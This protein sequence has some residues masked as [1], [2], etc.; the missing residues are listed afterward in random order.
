MKEINGW[1][2]G[3]WVEDEQS[4]VSVLLQFISRYMG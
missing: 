3:G 4:G 2:V 1:K